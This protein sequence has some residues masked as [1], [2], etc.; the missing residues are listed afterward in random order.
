MEGWVFLM[1][2]LGT[3]GFAFTYRTTIYIFD[4]LQRLFNEVNNVREE[5]R[6]FYK[7]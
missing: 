2:T 6:T 1:V 4:E 3:I 7:E 5:F